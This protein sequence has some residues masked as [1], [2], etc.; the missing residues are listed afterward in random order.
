[1]RKVYF[2]FVERGGRKTAS[3]TKIRRMNDEL[4]TTGAE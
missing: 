3:I 2:K 1:M 4:R